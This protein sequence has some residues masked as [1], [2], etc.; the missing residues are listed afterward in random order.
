MLGLLHMI[1]FSHLILVRMSVRKYEDNLI[2]SRKTLFTSNKTKKINNLKT[3]NFN[4]SVKK[5]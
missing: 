5:L 3:G 1:L 4:V 2:N